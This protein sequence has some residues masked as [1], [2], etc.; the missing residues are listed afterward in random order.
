M[1]ILTLELSIGLTMVILGVH[2]IVKPNFW[3]KYVPVFLSK[4]GF[5][6]I[7]RIRGIANIILGLLLILSFW[8]VIAT[9][10]CFLWWLFTAPFGYRVSWNIA[11]L[12]LTI[13]GSLL[14]LY[15]LHIAKI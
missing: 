2:E 9:L 6:N 15:F 5:E 10:I 12:D 13:A 4:I 8:N 3:V 1:V 11:L 7:I 14:A